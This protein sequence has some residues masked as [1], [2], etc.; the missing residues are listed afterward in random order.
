MTLQWD[1][2]PRADIAWLMLGDMIPIQLRV[3]DD[4]WSF[5]GVDGRRRTGSAS[6]REEA[7]RECL[8]QVRDVLR[9]A[10]SDLSAASG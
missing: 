7:R 8:K 4:G 5:R 10:L 2:T 3:E 1:T 6:S 9:S